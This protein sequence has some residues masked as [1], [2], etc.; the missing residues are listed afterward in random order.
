MTLSLNFA[1]LGESDL[2]LWQAKAFAGSGLVYA[3]DALLWVVFDRNF[4]A[5]EGFLSLDAIY[6]VSSE[7]VGQ[8]ACHLWAVRDAATSIFS[9]LLQSSAK[10][11]TR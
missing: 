10:Q 8:R 3:V 9:L 5:L 6:S 1:C 4:A 2:N 11:L 7:L